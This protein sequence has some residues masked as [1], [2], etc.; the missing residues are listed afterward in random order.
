MPRLTVS[1]RRTARHDEGKSM[2]TPSSEESW[3]CRTC[4]HPLIHRIQGGRA[5]LVHHSELRGGSEGHDPDPVTLADL[6]E[7]IRLCDFCA[8]PEVAWA[9]RCAER[10]TDNR[11]IV[12]QYVDQSDFLDRDRA[13][14]VRRTETT[15]GAINVQSATWLACQGCAEAIERGAVEELIS[16]HTDRLPTKQLKGRR[17]VLVR[18]I[19][20]QDFDH[21][22]ATRDPDRLRITPA[23]P[24]GEPTPQ[25]GAE[26]EW[27]PGD[28]VALVFTNDQ[29]T[30]L[31]PGDTGTVHAWMPDVGQLWIDWDTGSRLAMLPA[32]GD[33][34]ARI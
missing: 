16:R 18:A 30:N 22:L 6:P 23:H 26:P 15:S 11:R 27:R 3:F 31:V 13:A 33:Q 12:A 10:I 8:L 4:R 14:R 25:A 1:L 17:L 24:L 28:R 7:A 2:P 21:V 20:R 29:F 32:A 34:V 9:Y 19:L 5:Q